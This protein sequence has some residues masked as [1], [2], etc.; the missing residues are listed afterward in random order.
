LIIQLRN[1]LS[2][3]LNQFTPDLNDEEKLKQLIGDLTKFG[4]RI[5]TDNTSLNQ[6]AQVKN[7]LGIWRCLLLCNK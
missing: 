3:A 7:D 2:G 1:Q 4:I 6:L 5:Q